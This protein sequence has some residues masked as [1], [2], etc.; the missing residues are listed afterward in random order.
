MRIRN[1]VDE[2]LGLVAAILARLSIPMDSLCRAAELVGV[3][4]DAGKLAE[5]RQARR[6]AR[7]LALIRVVAADA[8]ANE[9]GTAFLELEHVVAPVVIGLAR[10][11]PTAAV[12]LVHV[13]LVV[14]QHPGGVALVDLGVD[15]ILVALA[16]GSPVH[17]DLLELGR[18][19]CGAPVVSPCS[20]SCTGEHAGDAAVVIGQAFLDPVGRVG[21]AGLERLVETG[22]CGWCGRGK[23]EDGQGHGSG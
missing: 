21:A 11:C 5:P 10:G 22:L 23:R 14:A 9:L 7:E 4:A 2:Q 12:V 17:G 6:I 1:I 16:A 20:A 13:G 3:V 15:A 8:G 19:G 18:V